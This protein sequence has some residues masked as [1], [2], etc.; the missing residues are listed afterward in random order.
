MLSIQ[1][2]GLNTRYIA[3][4][5]LPSSSDD[6]LVLLVHGAGGSSC[7]WEPMLKAWFAMPME[8]GLFPVA[9]DL[10]GHGASEGTVLP[11]IADIAAFLDAFL[12][13]LGI[14]NPVCYVGHS[15]GGLLGIQFALSYPHRVDR[16]VLMATSAQIQL[17]PD[18]LQQALTGDWDYASLQQSFAPDIAENLKQLVL[19]EFQHLR[20]AS[21]AADFMDL[22]QADLRA[23]LPTLPMPA[24]VVTGDDDV[25]ISPRKSKLLQRALPNA[26]LVTLPGAGHYVHVEQAA[27]VAA[28]LAHFLQQSRSAVCPV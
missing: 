18:F 28:T 24:L 7:H 1:C 14:T 21:E 2:S 23:A 17:H 26:S 20:L 16:L 6:Q 25:I 27:T 4:W 12:D 3:P 13:A 5:G 10:P 11:S 19:N 9:I 15:A 8:P 22:N